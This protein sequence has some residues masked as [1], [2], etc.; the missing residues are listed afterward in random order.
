MWISTHGISQFWFQTHQ[1]FECPSELVRKAFTSSR[2]YP[3]WYLPD[4][5]STLMAWFLRVFILLFAQR[6]SST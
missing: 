6:R 5:E 1:N 2:F 3:H 4:E